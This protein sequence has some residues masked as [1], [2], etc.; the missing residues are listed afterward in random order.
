MGTARASTRIPAATRST[1][2]LMAL[3]NRDVVSTEATVGISETEASLVR[4]D[5]GSCLP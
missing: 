2:A 3:T 1:I 4:L 5:L